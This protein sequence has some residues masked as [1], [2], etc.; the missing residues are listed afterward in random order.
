[1]HYQRKKISKEAEL[2]KLKKWISE[3]REEAK[4][5]PILVEGK[6]DSEALAKFGIKSVQLHQ[7]NNSLGERVDELSKYKECIL[8][9][10]L[11]KSGRKLNARIKEGLQSAGVKVNNQFRNF[12]FTKTKLRFIEG[13]D[14]YIKNLQ[15]KSQN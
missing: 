12:L 1:M 4:K 2:E 3:L 8:L 15:T 5:K 9:F 7:A 13:L 11:D 6:K 10:D 14:T